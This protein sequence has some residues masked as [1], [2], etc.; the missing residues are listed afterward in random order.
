MRC[1]CFLFCVVCWTGAFA[2]AT[3]TP[4][5][6]APTG[7]GATSLRSGGGMPVEY[8]TKFDEFGGVKISPDGQFIAALAGKYGRSMVV[9]IDLKEKKTVAHRQR[10]GRLRDRR[11]LLGVADAAD[12]HDRAAPARERAADADRRNLRSQS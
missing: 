4:Q 10:A 2:Q 7:A 9:F 6:S 11:V 12:L 3:A 1:L 5:S 8:F